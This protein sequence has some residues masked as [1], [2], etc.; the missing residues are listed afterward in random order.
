MII[1]VSIAAYYNNID[2]QKTSRSIVSFVRSFVRS[3][4]HRQTIYFIYGQEER[5][6]S[7]FMKRFSRVVSLVFV[8]TTVK[9]FK[10]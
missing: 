8:E 2:S 9:R 10:R 3:L 5:L 4:G 6:A 1:F 7:I